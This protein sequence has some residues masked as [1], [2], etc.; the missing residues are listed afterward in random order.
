MASIDLERIERVKDELK[1]CLP[2][3]NDRDS[4][5]VLLDHARSITNGHAG[6]AET[7]SRAIGGII[8]FL[9]KDRIRSRQPPPAPPSWKN[10]LISCR[11]PLAV[12]VSVVAIFSPHVPIILSFLNKFTS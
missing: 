7:M 6:D 1:R 10:I 3:G 8:V 12:T 9:V 4:C 11:W 2:P 5:Y